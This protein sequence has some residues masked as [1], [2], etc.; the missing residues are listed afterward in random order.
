MLY[1]E[2]SN[3]YKQLLDNQVNVVKQHDAAI[4]KMNEQTIERE[5]LIKQANI[6]S[7]YNDVKSDIYQNDIALDEAIYQNDVDAMQKRLA[8]YNKGSEEWLDLKAEMEQAAPDHQLQMQET[9]N[10]VKQSPMQP[11]EYQVI[12]MKHSN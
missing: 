3:E 10:I 9:S 4:L 5:R 1:G 11:T 6:K 2:K 8:L 12:C 7:Q